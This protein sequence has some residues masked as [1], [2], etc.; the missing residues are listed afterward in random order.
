LRLPALLPAGALL[1]ALLAMAG[2]SRADDFGAGGMAQVELGLGRALRL[3]PATLS[4]IVMTGIKLRGLAGNPWLQLAVGL[5]WHLG[6]AAPAGMLYELTLRPAGVA[7]A[8][9]KRARFIAT[10][11]VGFD[12][13]TGIMPVA[14]RFPVD[15]SLELDLGERAQ[16]CGWAELGWVAGPEARKAPSQL[17]EAADELS[18]GLAVR[19]LTGSDRESSGRSASGYFVGLAYSERFASPALLSVVGYAIDARFSDL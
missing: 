6:A 12:G 15:G 17:I 13:V 19:W 8:T 14:W 11:G 10:A 7:L 4:G 9:A 16:L 5:D 3:D 2:R 1:A 18:Y